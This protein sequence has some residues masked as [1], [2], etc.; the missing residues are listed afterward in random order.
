MKNKHSVLAVMSH[1]GEVSTLCFGTLA[2]YKKMGAKVSW[3]CVT[4]GAGGHKM[5][6]KDM[7]KL[8]AE[9]QVH[10]RATAKLIGANVSF[11][12]VQDCMAFK[13]DD[14][15]LKIVDVIRQV[16]PTVVITHYPDDHHPDNRYVSQATLTAAAIAS[17]FN[18]K[19]AHEATTVRPALFYVDAWVHKT[20]VPHHYV[21]ITSTFALKMKALANNKL[22][23]A[24]LRDFDNMSIFDLVETNA[25]A[26]GLQSGCKYAEAFQVEPHWP[27]PA[28]TYV[29][30]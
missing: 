29:L 26:H 3:C 1:P 24:W 12:G 27:S 2:K 7:A 25:K 10:E 4:D 8:A 30:P 20:F 28:S 15:I 21:D 6:P 9:R 16:Q 23:V 5:L 14:Y 18:I 19:T 11:L 22:G 17:T 13:M